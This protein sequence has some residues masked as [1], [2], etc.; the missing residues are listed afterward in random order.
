MVYN[1][2]HTKCSVAQIFCCFFVLC[3][4][5]RTNYRIP[6]QLHNVASSMYNI[7]M[8]KDTQLNIRVESKLVAEL[9]KLAELEVTTPSQIVRKAVT[10]YLRSATRGR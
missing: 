5:C 2:V 4:A 9:K 10:L 1:N 8:S 6:N 3:I 7:C